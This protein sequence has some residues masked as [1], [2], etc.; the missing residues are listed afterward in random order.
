MSWRFGAIWC[1]AGGAWSWASSQSVFLFWCSFT[2]CLILS[3]D[4]FNLFA[5]FNYE[6]TTFV[7]L[8]SV[9]SKFSYTA[10]YFESTQTKSA[11]VTWLLL[12]YHGVWYRKHVCFCTQV[13]WWELTKALRVTSTPFVNV[14]VLC[15][16]FW[17]FMENNSHSWIPDFRLQHLCER[18]Q[19]RKFQAIQ[20]F[21]QSWYA[22]STVS[23]CL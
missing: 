1:N 21:H 23:P 13:L 19:M 16:W 11:H 9:L 2:C 12:F 22:S 20:I 15:K 10:L 7:N 17:G 6:H 4:N 8:L 5:T 3:A 14:Q 18:T